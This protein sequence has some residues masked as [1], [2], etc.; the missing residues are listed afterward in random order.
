RFQVVQAVEEGGSVGP[1]TAVIRDPI[2][3]GGHGVLADAKM[4]VPRR[5]APVSTDSSVHMFMRDL[6]VLE[7]AI[8]LEG[9]VGGGVEVR[10][11]ADELGVVLRDGGQGLSGRR[12]G[13]D[14]LFRAK[15]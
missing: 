9:G 12:A 8:A 15:R 3:R 1:E 11:A 7:I 2:A 4:Q 13:S 6:G 14:R 5:V 10:R